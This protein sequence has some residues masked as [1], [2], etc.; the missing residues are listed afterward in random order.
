MKLAAQLES[1]RDRSPFILNV[2]NAA[3][4]TWT[5]NA[6]LAVGAE[7]IFAQTEGELPELV[8]K[9][10]AVVVTLD[11]SR[12]QAAGIAFQ[13]AAKRGRAC[14]FD[15]AGADLS[16]ARADLAQ[17]LLRE[18]QPHF[19]RAPPAEIL[20]LAGEDPRQ[21]TLD[22]ALK[23]AERIVRAHGSTVVVSGAVDFVL[24][25]EGGR[26]RLAKTMNGHPWMTR[27]SGM[28]CASSSFVGAFACEGVD[29][30]RSA[31]A[32][33]AYLGYCG[34]RAAMRARGPGEMQVALLDELSSVHP[35]D[36]EAQSVTET[37]E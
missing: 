2:T 13:E 21:P 25:L 9:A 34:E 33:M 5:S 19:L 4:M 8:E 18:H 36:F 16:R 10:A 7:S 14:V 3:A 32:A 17:R 6:L 23:A 35:R 31:T 1:L 37:L 15:P 30:W 12:E 27:I 26:C 24:G 28:G 22:R 20:A 11:P 29:S